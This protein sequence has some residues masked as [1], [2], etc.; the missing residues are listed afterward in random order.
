MVSCLDVSLPHASRDDGRVLILHVMLSCNDS[1]CLLAC[2]AC[3]M[4]SMTTWGHTSCMSHMSGDGEQAH[5]EGT[6][7]TRNLFGRLH[8]VLGM[9]PESL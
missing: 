7:G 1:A 3:N 2:A 8:G 4:I 9:V 5:A 6:R